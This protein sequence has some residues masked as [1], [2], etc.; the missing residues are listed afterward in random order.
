MLLTAVVPFAP[1]A[2][3]AAVVMAIS[4]FCATVFSVNLYSMPLE[5]FGRGRAAFAIS[6]L[7]SAYGLMQAV[8]SVAAGSI[9]DHYGFKLVCMVIAVL[10]LCAAFLLSRVKVAV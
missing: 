3:V 6:S 7:T 1:S 5:V 10:P 4:Y 9:I 8:M 2:L